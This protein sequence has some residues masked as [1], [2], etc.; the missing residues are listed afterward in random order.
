MKRVR[1]G[2]VVGAGV[3]VVFAC[4]EPPPKMSLPPGNL[5][6]KVY[7]FGASAQ[8]ARRTFEAAKQT[9]QGF[10]VVNEGGDGEVL[11]GLEN[12]SPKCVQ[13]TALCSFRYAYRVKSYKGDV[14][15]TGSS[16]VSANS[17]R[18]A[19]LC[20]KA[21]NN[22][23]VKVVESAAAALKNGAASAPDD[24]GIEAAAPEAE[25]DPSASA[26][27]PPPPVPK[28]KGP[29]AK[30][31][32]EPA[33]PPKPAPPICAVASGPRLASDEAERRAAQVDVLKRLNVIDQEEYDCLRKA[34][35][36]RL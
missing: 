25:A 2:F 4:V 16:T 12:D 9:N 18:C 22:L 1:I 20:S 35:L 31:P 3:A 26:S 13:P 33:P 7:V 27:A 14:V 32:P 5:A 19:D 10:S 24:A 8:E 29:L 36:D 6:L 11:I 15:A 17:D 34:Y 28:K 23:V 21:L 30:K